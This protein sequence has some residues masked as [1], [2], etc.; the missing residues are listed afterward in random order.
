MLFLV[1]SILSMDATAATAK[2]D[3]VA[4]TNVSGVKVEGEVTG[5]KVQ[6]DVK[7]AKGAIVSMDAFDLKT[8][9]DT[10]DEH[11]REKVFAAKKEGEVKIQF[12]VKDLSCS[13]KCK[14][15][16]VLKIKDIEKELEIPVKANA[17]RSKISG[18]AQV[19]LTEFNLK[20]P[21]FMGVKVEESVD[22]NFE[23]QE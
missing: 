8:G 21:S 13:E 14:V 1:L 6:Y 20:R 3:F 15:T 17:E 5:A 12:T 4:H 18:V 9:M 11:L 23:I 19:N 7:N 2:I 10:R 22:I 16:G